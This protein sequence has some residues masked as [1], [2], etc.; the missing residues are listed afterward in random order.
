LK[1]MVAD[2]IPW[3]ANR[4]SA[5]CAVAL[6]VCSLAPFVAAAEVATGHILHVSF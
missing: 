6:A 3:T 5:H 1:P 4:S 2:G